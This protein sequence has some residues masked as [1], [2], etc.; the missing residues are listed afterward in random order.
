LK[1]SG[2]KF[3]F[4]IDASLKTPGGY[5]PNTN[6]IK[7]RSTSD[8]NYN[9][10][11]EELFHA[12]QHLIDNIS[13]HL[14]SPYL[15]RSN[16]EFEA[17]LYIDLIALLYDGTCCLGGQSN[18]YLQWLFSITNDGQT[19]PTW[20]EIQPYYYYFLELFKQEKPAYNFPTNL[21]LPPNTLFLPFRVN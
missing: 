14:V 17:K 19:A 7:F 18:E 9:S 8:I 13:E 10:L 4:K 11:L 2:F 16:I 3:T 12:Y 15:G 5:D 1:S 20:N 6:T 21:E